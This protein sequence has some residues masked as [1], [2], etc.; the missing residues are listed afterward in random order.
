MKQCC[1]L[2]LF[3]LTGALITSGCV[4]SFGFAKAEAYGVVIDQDGLPLTDAKVEA[5][6]LPGC[7]FPFIRDS[8]SK[9]IPIKSDGSWRF[10]KR[11]IENMNISAYA[12]KGYEPWIAKNGLDFYPGQCMSNVVFQF[13]KIQPTEP[14]KESK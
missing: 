2:T 9:T 11:N 14:A 10:V 5:S 1:L 7:L 4:S 13:H 6:W 8:K 3:L 12:P